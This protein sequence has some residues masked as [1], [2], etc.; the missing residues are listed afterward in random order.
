MYSFV[1]NKKYSQIWRF[2]FIAAYLFVSTF[3]MNF[4]DANIK[5]HWNFLVSCNQWKK[6][7]ISTIKMPDF[8]S[9]LLFELTLVIKLTNFD[10]KSHWN[11]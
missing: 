11:T 3:A 10:Y 2:N 4:E 7:W 5:S 1:K 8:A 9:F 6:I